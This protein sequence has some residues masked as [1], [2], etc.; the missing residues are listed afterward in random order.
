MCY[1]IAR[2]CG[3]IGCIAL[4]ISHGPPLVTLKQKLIGIIG[5]GPVEMVTISR[6][7]AYPE[8]APYNVA[9]TED[10]FILAVMKLYESTK[11]Q[12]NLT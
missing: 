3:S 2:C 7:M 6:P 4:R 11:E 5:Y 8:Y 12:T 9:A 1:L 10:E